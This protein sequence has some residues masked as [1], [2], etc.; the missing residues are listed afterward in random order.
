MP[1]RVKIST[2]K[3]TVAL[4]SGIGWLSCL[5]VNVLMPQHSLAQVST[6]DAAMAP[7]PLETEVLQPFFSS[8][9]IGE[10][11]DYQSSLISAY[12]STIDADPSETEGFYRQ[13]LQLGTHLFIGNGYESFYEDDQLSQFRETDF[14]LW[15][16]V[17]SCVAECTQPV[18]NLDVDAFATWSERTDTMADDDF[19]AIIRAYYAIANYE[20]EVDPMVSDRTLIGAPAYFQYTWD[21]GGYSLLGEGKH[22]ALLLQ[23]DRYQQQHGDYLVRSPLTAFASQLQEMRHDLLRDI[24]IVSDCSGPEQEKIVAELTQILAQTQ[25][26]PA[27]REAIANRLAEFQTPSSE[28]Q[29]NC[30][31]FGTCSCEGG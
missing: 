2:R 10:A 25:L 22:L 21:Y 28:I 26:G 14:G 9:Q 7:A 24:L 6:E 29:T 15:G 31:E 19:F 4:A 12:N 8:W 1:K 13:A 17:P 30:Q 11:N 16:L 23:L 5:S 20:G 3:L 27:E 18:F